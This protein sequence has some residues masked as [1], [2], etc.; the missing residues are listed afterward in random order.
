M[1]ISHYFNINILFLNIA[2]RC[3]VVNTSLVRDLSCG[4]DY[5]YLT[6]PDHC[7]SH[8]MNIHFHGSKLN[9]C[10]PGCDYPQLGNLLC[11]ND[12]VA[13]TATAEAINTNKHFL[14]AGGE[15][16]LVTCTGYTGGGNM[17]IFAYCLSCGSPVNPDD[18]WQ[19]AP[20]N[21]IKT[22]RK[23]LDA[24]LSITTKTST[25][26][27][28]ITTT[29]ATATTATATTTTATTA[30]STTVL[31]VNAVCDPHND[32]CD[33]AKGLMCNANNYQCRYRT[34]VTATTTSRTVTTQTVTT[35]STTTTSGTTTTTTRGLGKKCNTRIDHCSASLDLVCVMNPET[36]E[37]HCV[38]RT[39]S[40][41]PQPKPTTSATTAFTKS[42]RSTAALPAVAST[43]TTPVTADTNTAKTNT[44]TTATITATNQISAKTTSTSKSPD[45][46][47]LT[48]KTD[49]GLPLSI[50]IG[51][52][53]GI[54]L[55]LIVIVVVCRQQKRMR[56]ENVVIQMQNAM[57]NPNDVNSSGS[58]GDDE[59]LLDFHDNEDATL[60]EAL[61]KFVA[62]VITLGK[63]VIASK[64]LP[65]F[66]G[67]DDE[68]TFF[69]QD[70]MGAILAEFET[71]GN[72]EDKQNARTVLDGTYVN[73]PDPKKPGQVPVRCKSLDELMGAPE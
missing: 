26:S 59:A 30:T 38:P 41:D 10:A 8:D 71:H 1:R 32:A 23:A 17:G 3:I 39:S 40:P 27:T 9:W 50:I 53:A 24:V 72:D 68:S 5:G 21:Y 54:V 67:I 61:S 6:T 49:E 51:A 12:L 73:P 37:G 11:T 35:T 69:V 13:C 19:A 4:H 70:R 57:W 62:P 22:L 14:A 33:A 28:T 47:V 34:T 66:L 60:A 55:L 25:T 20:S 18:Y 64:G 42:T 31:P 58:G 36:R 56:R 52:P 65:A 48:P 46:G 63:S 7:I 43:A 45:D 2:F 16:S 44:P 15:A 29:T